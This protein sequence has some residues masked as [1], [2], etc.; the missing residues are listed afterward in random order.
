METKIGTLNTE[1]HTVPVTFTQ[2]DLVYSRDVNAC[3]DVGGDYDEAATKERVEQVG[4]GVAQKISLG[5]IARE[6][7]APESDDA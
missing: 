1:T 7:P 3:F 4:R 5:V 6:K 2:G